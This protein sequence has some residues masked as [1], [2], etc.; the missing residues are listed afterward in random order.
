MEC[1][2]VISKQGGRALARARLAWVHPK[3]FV[4]KALEEDQATS[5]GRSSWQVEAELKEPQNH[6]RPAPSSK[7][8]ETNPFTQTG[9]SHEYTGLAEADTNNEQSGDYTQAAQD[10]LHTTSDSNLHLKPTQKN[11]K[12]S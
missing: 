11:L 3:D 7:L 5:G 4:L 2:T 9:P 12:D 1:L 8:K 6:H 10:Q